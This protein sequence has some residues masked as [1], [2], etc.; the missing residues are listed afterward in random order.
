[1]H[2]NILCITRAAINLSGCRRANA[3]AATVLAVCSAAFLIS[4]VHYGLTAAQLQAAISQAP[5]LAP[6]P[7]K[8]T[9]CLQ[10]R[11]CSFPDLRFCA[12]MWLTW[13]IRLGQRPAGRQQVAAGRLQLIE[14]M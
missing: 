11:A 6:P 10:V 14:A 8:I 12:C 3:A 7:V 13:T 1:M 9:M 2:T 5:V 4:A